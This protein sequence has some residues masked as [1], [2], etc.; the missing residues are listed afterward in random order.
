MSLYDQIREASPKRSWE[1]VITYY[2]KEYPGSKTNKAGVTSY[3]W[4]SKLATDVSETTGVERKSVMRRFQKRAGKVAPVSEKHQ[5]EYADVGEA[6]PPKV[7]EG[8]YHISGTVWVKYSDDV[9]DAREIDEAISGEDAE[10]LAKLSPD[11]MMQGL[12][13]Y[14]Q[15]G[16]ISGRGP[17]WNA[18]ELT[19]S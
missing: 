17:G 11:Q 8:G 12:V 19:V 13:N 14:Y 9:Y 3:A 6:L 15:T 4:Q 2:K 1:E 18:E 5:A 16:D 7:P 10:A